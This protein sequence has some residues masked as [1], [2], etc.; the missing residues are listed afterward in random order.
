M[1]K[2]KKKMSSFLSVVRMNWYGNGTHFSPLFLLSSVFLHACYFR[3]ENATV[4]AFLVA[5]I[6]D[7]YKSKLMCISNS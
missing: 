4:I 3:G 1:K 6:K 2:V 7:A 5:F